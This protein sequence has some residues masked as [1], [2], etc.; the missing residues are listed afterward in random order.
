MDITNTNGAA[1]YVGVMQLGGGIGQLS[2]ITSA[3]NIYYNA[4]LAANSYL[5]G[6]N[7]A[8]AVG[9]ELMAVAAVPEPETYAMMLAGL[10]LMGCVAW[11]K[12]AV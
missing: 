1:L 6:K 8:L 9:G 4:T 12:K 3:D 7:Y 10:G 5:G 2:N 11:R